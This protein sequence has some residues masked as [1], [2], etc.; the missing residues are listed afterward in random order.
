MGSIKDLFMNLDLSDRGDENAVE[1]YADSVKHALE[2]ASRELGVDVSLLDYEVLEKGTSGFFGIGRLPYR[3]LVVPLVDSR[4][5]EDL[6]ALEQKLSKEHVVSHAFADGSFTVRVT[7]SGIWLTV[8][9]PK[10]KGRPVTIDDV[11][12]K[13]Y[14]MKITPSDFA[15][16]QREVEKPSG[17]PIKIGNWTPNPDYDGSMT[18]EMTED[19]MKVYLHFTPPRY[20]GRHLEYE[21]VI[22]ALKRA[23]VRVGIREKEIREYLDRMDYSMPLLAAAGTPPVNG[24]DA[25]ID[26]KVRVEDKGIA[27]EED[28]SGKVDFRNLELLENVVAGQL[29]AVKVPAEKGVDGRTVTNRVIPARPGKDIKIQYGKG[30]ILS[31]DGMELTAEINGQVV[32]KAGKISVDPVYLVNGDVTMEIGNIVFLGSVIVTGSVPD[33]FEIKAAGNIEVRGVVEKANL[34]AEG[35]VVIFGGITGRDGARIESTGGSVY[36]KFIQNARIIAEMNVVAPESIL[37]SNVDAGNGVFTMGKSARIVGG[38][39]RAGNEVNA[40]FIGTDAYTKTEVWVGLHPKVLQQLSDLNQMKAKT[41]EEQVKLRL[42]I[43]T[44]ETQKR[45]AGSRFPAEKEKQ[46][47]ELQSRDAKL[48]ERLTEI[49]HELEEIKSY[50]AMSEFRGKVCAEKTAYPG[51]EIHI[52]DQKYALKDPYNHVKFFLEGGHIRPG[53]Y[54]PPEGVDTKMIITRRR[55]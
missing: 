36:A 29:L 46:L 3:V 45:N 38:V 28:E 7:K 18:L 35:D 5:K 15:K 55:R 33:G 2:L 27:F 14:S 21:E 37:H 16:V 48:S 34:E 51:V 8:T 49:S 52:K 41:E 6:D 39:I 24:K 40:R 12:N 32:F 31:E 23:G 54:E 22:D 17:K 30:T 19:E 1:V 53:M 10:G 47:A 42:D 9:P 13:L 44:L 50:I 11:N 43:R 25:Y 4:G 20:S 26:Y